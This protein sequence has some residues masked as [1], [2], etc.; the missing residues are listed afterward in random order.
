MLASPARHE[1][2]N[3]VLVKRQVTTRFRTLRRDWPQTGLAIVRAQKRV[4]PRG[5]QCGTHRGKAQ[6]EGVEVQ[7]I[8]GVQEH[9][10]RTAAAE[11]HLNFREGRSALRVR[12]NRFAIRGSGRLQEGL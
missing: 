6:I 1:E 5:T 3:E 7:Q 4:R 11:V 10:V 8:E 12:H 9:A 2:P